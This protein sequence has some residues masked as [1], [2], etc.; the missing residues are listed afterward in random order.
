MKLIIAGGRE[1]TFR[2]QDYDRL[3]QLRH[4]ITIT[5]VVCGGATG[6]D[7]QGKLWAESYG[8]PVRV[9]EAD[10]KRYGLRAGPLRNIEMAAYADALALF[11][12][13]SG[14]ENMLKQARKAGLRIFDCR[15]TA[16]QN[17]LF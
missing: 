7:A 4:E 9:F 6:A 8:I 3:D 2:P 13:G 10:W 15:K 12:G 17:E 16:K 14:T 1:Y 11:P 5:E